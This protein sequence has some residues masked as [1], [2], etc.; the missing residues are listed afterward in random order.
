MAERACGRCGKTFPSQRSVTSNYGRKYCS[1]ACRS[2]AMAEHGRSYSRV[3]LMVAGN[4]DRSREF[5]RQRF[6]QYAPFSDREIA[7]MRV[8]TKWA[9]QRGRT[10]E[11]RTA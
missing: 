8:V 3:Y 11:R 5:W 10:A 4:K 6:E 7:L 2:E 1:D 9:Y